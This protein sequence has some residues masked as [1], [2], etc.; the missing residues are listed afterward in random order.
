V[1]YYRMLEYSFY[2]GCVAPIGVLGVR[3]LVL[4]A[5]S[6]LKRWGSG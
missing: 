4:W 1:N 3:V 6:M 2:A 5:F